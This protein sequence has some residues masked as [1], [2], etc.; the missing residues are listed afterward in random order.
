MIDLFAVCDLCRSLTG[1]PLEEGGAEGDEENR[2]LEP[3]GEREMNDIR[4]MRAMDYDMRAMRGRFKVKEHGDGNVNANANANNNP[5]GSNKSRLNAMRAQLNDDKYRLEEQRASQQFDDEEERA[6]G[7][8]RR[9][10]N[11]HRHKYARP[12]RGTFDGFDAFWHSIGLGFPLNLFGLGVGGPRNFG[13][14]F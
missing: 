11:R 2:L 1:I 9:P 6:V 10:V 13:L 14:F 12:V 5:V 7:Y 3:L 8:K 4:A